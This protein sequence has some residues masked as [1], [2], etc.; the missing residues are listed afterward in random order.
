VTPTTHAVVSLLDREH[1]RL[2]EELW[3]RLRDRFGLRGVDR[4]PFPHVTYVV[5]ESGDRAMLES[6]LASLAGSRHS[7][8]LLATGLGVFPG[9]DPVLYVPVVRSASL[10]SIHSA[11]EAAHADGGGAVLEHY[12]SDRW[13]PH[14]TLAWGDVDADI[15]AAAVGE[16][17]GTPIDWPVSIDNLTLVDPE[18]GD[19]EG[20]RLQ[21]FALNPRR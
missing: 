1:C 17:A 16:L 5:A 12:R 18:P 19:G 4:A 2:V 8:T 10:S 20:L 9:D 15:L 11:I 7:F 14:I 3:R 21:R 13:L 6:R